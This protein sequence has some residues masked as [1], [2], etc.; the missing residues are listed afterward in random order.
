MNLASPE[1][2]AF[3][4]AFEALVYPPA[5][6]KHRE[7]LRLAYT[8]LTESDTDTAHAQMRSAILAFLSHHRVDPAKYH[9]T[10]TRAWILAVRHFMAR[11]PDTTSFDA[12][13]AANPV[14][15]D[16]KIMLTHYSAERLSSPEARLT[17]VAPDRAPIPRHSA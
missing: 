1:D 17:F 15:L 12:L 10:I 14:M 2:T 8:Y 5:Q 7:H 16:S 6:F 13:A 3:R 9:E 11:T 4:R